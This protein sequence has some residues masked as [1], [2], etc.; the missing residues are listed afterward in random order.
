[1]KKIILHKTQKAEGR[2]QKAFLL[3]NMLYALAIL[4]LSA[5]CFLPSALTAQ[6]E[7]N[8][9]FAIDSLQKIELEVTPEIEKMVVK[10]IN[11]SPEEFHSSIYGIKNKAQIEHLHLG[12][13]FPHYYIVNERLDPSNESV[14]IVSTS[15]ASRTVDGKPL[16]LR[17]ANYWIVPVMSGDEPLAFGEIRPYFGDDGYLYFNE[18]SYI[19]RSKTENIAKHFQ[20]YEYKDSVIG[21]VNMDMYYFIIRKENK[22]LFVE[23][24][25]EIT[26][27][28]FKNEYSFSELINHIKELNLRKQEAQRRY[29]AQ[30]A[31]KTE[32]EITPEIMEMVVGEALSFRG[33]SDEELSNWGIKNRA[34]L[35]KEKI[36]PGKPIPKYRLFDEN[37]TFIGEWFVPVMSDG[38]PIL[39]VT[40]DL[41]DNGQ[42][43]WGGT[44]GAGLPELILNYEHKDLIVG[45]LRIGFGPAYLMIRKDNKDIFVEGH[46]YGTGEEAFDTEYSFDEVMDNLK[47]R[48][49]NRNKRYEH[50]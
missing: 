48:I 33:W 11:D 17:F 44:G 45:Y 22:P 14:A 30:I 39:M 29:F 28:Y 7:V 10:K 20:N 42:Y 23:V 24:Y 38:E 4:F 25:N 31:N 2:K 50:E 12:K 8:K 1:M 35:V 32:L 43:R 27:E 37:V 13:P 19:G 21:S 41:K 15:N 6:V 49:D 18:Y 5:F 3:F 16:S 47:K 46:V 9:I 26:D 40:V 36:Y 34:L